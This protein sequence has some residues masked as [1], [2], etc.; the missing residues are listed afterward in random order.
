MK[1]PEQFDHHKL[2]RRDPQAL[3][4]WFLDHADAVYTFVYYRVG[5]ERELA[6]RRV[7]P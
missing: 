5:R 4:R 3:E 6:A 2:R 7:T 1:P